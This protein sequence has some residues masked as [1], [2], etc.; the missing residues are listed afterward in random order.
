ME[1][2]RRLSSLKKKI[3]LFV[4]LCWGVPIAVFFAYTTSSYRKGIIEKTEGLMEDQLENMASFA[5]IRIEDAITLCQRPSYEKTWENAW[6]KYLRGDYS[7]NDYLQDVYTSL[8]GKFYLDERF[9]MYAYYCYGTED[10]ESFSSRTGISLKSYVDEIQPYLKD[11]IDSD[12]AYAC[13]RVVDGRIFIVRNLYTTMDYTRYGTLVVE[14]NRSKVF[15]DVDTGL[16][17]DMVVCFGSRDARVDFVKNEE[18]SDKEQLLEQLLQKY[19][20]VSNHTFSKAEDAT[21]RAYLYQERRDDFHIGIVLFARKSELYSG[22]YQFYTIVA[23]MFLLLIPLFGYVVYF[24]RRNIQHPIDRMLRASGRMEAGEMGITVEG[25]M[26]NQEFMQMKESF[27]SMSAQV[28]YLFDSM[29]SE[30]LARKDAQIQALQ[31]QIN[32]HF[33]NNTLE[34]MNW[35]AR[36]SGATVVSKMIESLGTVLDYRMNR[37]N[38]KEIHLAEEL[39]CID[40]YFYIMSM[41]F[42]QRLSIE[43]KIDDDLLYL[44]VPPLIL[45]PI[46]ENAIV[47]GVET[48]KNGVIRLHVY[49]DDE[50]VYLKV[51]NTGKKM[52]EEEL[53]RIHAILEGDESRLPKNTGRHTSIG[54]QNVNRRIRLVYG[55]E[56]GLSIEQEEDCITVSTI[57]IPYVDHEDEISLKERSE[58]QNELKNIARLNK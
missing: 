11:I 20:G 48:V 30:K 53:E 56:Y 27:D 36:M 6:K 54:I 15:Q 50:N 21:Y 12:S 22:L 32:P 47:H 39:Q 23:L 40:A 26:P 45:Q 41:R 31:A 58:A 19:D 3:I 38:V 1:K 16:L 17:N 34:M 29:Y 43:R 9:N 18:K 7:R 57:T 55:D 44:M 51:R 13:V 52:T 24:I 25:D 4:I 42:G 14:L 49:H 46:V 35:Q 5:S 37:A 10:P 8:R 2:K 33:L 28:K